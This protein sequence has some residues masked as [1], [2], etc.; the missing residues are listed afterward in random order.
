M[1]RGCRE[2]E[3]TALITHRLNCTE[4]R[5]IGL[6]FM[7]VKPDLICNGVAY[8]IECADKVHY[9]VG[10]ALAYQYGGYKAGLIVIVNDWG[11]DELN[12][13]MDFLKWVSDRFGIDVLILKCAG[14]D[15]EFVKVTGWG[16]T[17]SKL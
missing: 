6:G 10:Q 14:Y 2:D 5:P 7:S 15:C 4:A 9:G 13:L 8:E 12:Q 1:A 17:H 3:Y 11:N 16:L